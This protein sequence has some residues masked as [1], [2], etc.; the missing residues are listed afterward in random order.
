MRHL[1]YTGLL[2]MV[3]LVIASCGGT[4]GG[5]GGTERTGVVIELG[6]R[7]VSSIATAAVEYDYL[8]I[9]VSAPDMESIEERIG[10]QGRE[11]VQVSLLVPNGLN[12][13]FEAFAYSSSAQG[14]G[15]DGL[16]CY[17]DAYADLFGDPLT[18]TLIMV[19]GAD[20]TPPLFDGLVSATA[21]SATEIALGWD[22]ATDDVT[23]SSN[24]QYLIYLS[25]SPGGQ[26][27]STPDYTTGPGAVTYTVTGLNPSTTYCFV[28]RAK[29]EAG[30]TDDNTVERCA[31]TFPLTGK[32]T[33][34]VNTAGSGSGTV[35]SYPPGIACGVNCIESYDAG[36]VVTLTPE[37]DPGSIFEGWSG[38]P[39]CSDGVV[40]MDADKACTAIFEQ[41]QS[42]YNLTVYK[43]GAGSGTVTSDPPGITCGQDCSALFLEG[44]LVSLTP[45]PEKGSLFA[46]W[47]G[48]CNSDGIVVMTGDKACTATFEPLRY[49][50][51]V[52]ISGQGSINIWSDPPG[53]DCNESG[54][55]CTEPYDYGTIV[56]LQYELSNGYFCGWSGDPDCSDGMVTMTGDRT[57]T[58]ITSLTTC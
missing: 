53:I 41:Y 47:S 54:G 26:D 37:P 29:D 8:V 12:R 14:V 4:G 40:T 1:L 49:T 34:T 50:L 56:T 21:V 23:P 13:H 15:E 7:E 11:S 31:T 35:T 6:Q 18:I 33:L 5:G 30:N 43:A 24:I 32:F 42:W 3:F 38:D 16:L 48:D 22:P 17:G 28:V 10:L 44:T 57:C 25:T 27:F 20:D 36:T 9:R 39:D 19:C 52:E 55:D 2:G 58:A 46:G 45:E 51:T